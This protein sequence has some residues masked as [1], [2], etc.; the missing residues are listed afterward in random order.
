MDLGYCERFDQCLSVNSLP[1]REWSEKAR[2]AAVRELCETCPY[3]TVNRHHIRQNPV[4]KTENT[5][6]T[7]LL[8]S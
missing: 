6:E 7:R 8:M 3:S 4:R 5:A 1:D 2:I